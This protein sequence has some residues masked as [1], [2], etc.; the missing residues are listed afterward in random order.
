MLD[1][2]VRGYGHEGIY[3][4][5]GLASAIPR[6]VRWLATGEGGDA[7]GDL[8]TDEWA[9]AIKA[10]L[11]AHAPITGYDMYD[12]VV[13]AA[14]VDLP[15]LQ[16]VLCLLPDTAAL[17]LE[18]ILS[19]LARLAAHA[20]T[21]LMTASNL[22]KLWGSIM[23]RPDEDSAVELGV[24]LRMA[25]R[26]YNFANM[27][28]EHTLV[29]LRA[30]GDGRPPSAPP[31]RLRDE[32]DTARTVVP[33]AVLHIVAPAREAVI[34]LQGVADDSLEAAVE[35]LQEEHLPHTLHTV[36][37][38]SVVRSM[39]TVY[40][41]RT[42][43]S[44]SRPPAAAPAAAGGGGGGGGGGG[45]TSLPSGAPAPPPPTSRNIL[46][47][48]SSLPSGSA[49]PVAAPAPAPATTDGPP[50]RT[51]LRRA[52]Q[53]LTGGSGGSGSGS[54]A[55]H[56]GSAGASPSFG[57]APG[58]AGGG[59]P[60]VMPPLAPSSMSMDG[61][62]GG[63]GRGGRLSGTAVA[64]TLPTFGGGLA[65]AGGGM[66]GGGGGMAGGGGGM[67]GGGRAYTT[68]VALGGGGDDAAR[69][70]AARWD[71]RDLAAQLAEAGGGTSAP[72]SSIVSER[73]PARDPLVVT[74]VAATGQA[75]SWSDPFGGGGGGGGGRA[76]TGPA[77]LTA[78][79][80]IMSALDV[81]QPGGLGSP[82]S[83]AADPLS[84]PSKA[85]Y[86]DAPA[87]GG[88]TPVAEEGEGGGSAEDDDDEGGAAEVGRSGRGS[89][90]QPPRPPPA[91][92]KPALSP[93]SASLPVAPASNG[94]SD[95]EGSSGSSGRGGGG[96][97][98]TSGGGGGG[99]GRSG[100]GPMRPAVFA[101]RKPP[102]PSGPQPGGPST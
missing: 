79:D 71:P 101:G 82:E 12:A 47:R 76:V 26:Q 88:T 50:P 13:G 39:R 18:F 7:L 57:A 28:L 9:S 42:A 25:A 83:A 2:E 43:S 38:R 93:S 60:P 55:V 44:R 61:G 91:Y 1:L 81:G 90:T 14:A 36:S 78:I 58:H 92:T 27:L 65:A 52:S 98:G 56:A 80:E 64:P 49:L 5:P 102:A 75:R 19:H 6:G 54:P 31:P 62:G 72:R 8:Y 87:A 70:R 16:T 66:A 69:R 96:G 95:E 34:A 99:G 73:V 17:R 23:A 29:Q 20:A 35:A 53:F 22:A 63:G 85:G 74:A 21:N 33:G 59:M 45:H 15:A 67:G 11:R 4:V 68:G 41:E 32:G 37:A 89:A 46:R 77:N 84:S 48:M 51:W 24:E 86:A 40:A 30:T 94:S 100:T 10:C 3:R 97:G